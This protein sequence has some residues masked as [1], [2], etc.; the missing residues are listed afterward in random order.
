MLSGG[1]TA[2]SLGIVLACYGIPRAVLTVPGGSL[3]DRLG[4]R[5]VMLSSDLARCALTAALAV[6]A[7]SHDASLAALAPVAALLGAAS[8]LFMPASMTMMPSLVEASG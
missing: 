5:R 6:L 8:A 7:A 2:A 4:P 1:G 3:A